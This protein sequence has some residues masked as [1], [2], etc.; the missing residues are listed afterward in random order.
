MR[1]VWRAWNSGSR[2][3]APSTTEFIADAGKT[4]RSTTRYL[5]AGI[6]KKLWMGYS[7]DVGWNLSM[8][9]SSHKDKGRCS[10]IKYLAV[11]LGRR[12]QEEPFLDQ[13][14]ARGRREEALA[15]PVRHRRQQVDGVFADEGEGEGMR[16]HLVAYSPN[17]GHSITYST[18]WGKERR[19]SI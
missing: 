3:E 13:V 18:N 14:L 19:C 1:L 6:N 16:K 4:S 5:T 10:L 12:L 11:V 17:S 9:S 15:D 7:P 2:S 8:V